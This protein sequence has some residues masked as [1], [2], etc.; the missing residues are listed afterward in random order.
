MLT[1]FQKSGCKFR[2]QLKEDIYY[3]ELDFA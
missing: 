3:F 2:S 1:V